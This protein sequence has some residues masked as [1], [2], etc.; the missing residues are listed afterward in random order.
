MLARV[1]V[2]YGQET[3]NQQEKLSLTG[4]A[5]QAAQSGIRDNDDTDQ[6]VLHLDR[7]A[8]ETD[9][10]F[11]Y[12]QDEDAQDRAPDRAAAAGQAG[13]ADDH[14]R[15]DLQFQPLSSI[16]IAARTVGEAQDAGPANEQP[17]Q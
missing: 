1:G 10:V 3:G 6:D 13:T 8:E 17:R 15:D 12:S 14:R 7:H 16:G 9:A 5:L 2:F 4:A 11:Q